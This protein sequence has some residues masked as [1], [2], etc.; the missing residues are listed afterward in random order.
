MA[1]SGLW[2]LCRDGY[3]SL[4]FAIDVGNFQVEPLLETETARVDGHQVD[5]V[6]EG[7]DFGQDP[8]DF[9]SGEDGGEASLP[10]GL[11]Q[12]KQ[13]PVALDNIFKEEFDARV[14]DA[15][16]GWRPPGFVLPVDEIIEEFLF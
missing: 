2:P 4:A 9:F 15:H 11:G 16:G 12:C 14:A 3:G 1:H 5:I 8:F 6:V 10:L 7:I 13:V